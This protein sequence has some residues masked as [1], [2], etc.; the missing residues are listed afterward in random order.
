MAA[1]TKQEKTQVIAAVVNRVRRESPGGGFVKRDFHSGLWY[2]IGDDKA[3]D[4]VGHAIRKAVEEMSKKS[5]KE[6]GG[7]KSKQAI[8]KMGGADTIDAG[9]KGLDDLT[10]QQKAAA[11]L[12]GNAQAAGPGGLAG[13][14]MDGLVM[15]SA[16]GYSAQMQ[17]NANAAG[18]MAHSM[19]Q[20]MV[21]PPGAGLFQ[22]AGPHAFDLFGGQAM[23][24]F[25]GDGGL[26]AAAANS[27][28]MNKVKEEW[29]QQESAS[30]L[31]YLF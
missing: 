21:V 26:F 30:Q 14:S 6:K 3:R 4:K 16:F 2:E 9:A 11:V 31:R 7:S 24:Q 29:A 20:S 1:R 22:Q 17:Q 13:A 23:N 8:S 27:T 15:P 18:A 28:L 12:R 5:K 19:Q 25:G 10:H